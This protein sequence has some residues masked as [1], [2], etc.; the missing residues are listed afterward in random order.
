MTLDYNIKDPQGRVDQVSALIEE[1]QSEGKELT[2]TY[3]E[4]LADYIC[5]AKETKDRAVLTPNRMVTVNKRE[6]SYEGLAEQVEGEDYVQMLKSDNRNQILSPKVEITK[7]D[8]AEIPALAQLRLSIEHWEKLL[9][10]A[11]GKRAFYI[12]KALIEMRKDQYLIKQAYKPMIKF[13]SI[14]RSS[15]I[16]IELPGDETIGEDGEP[17][18]RGISLL[19]PKVVSSILC[20]YTTLNDNQFLDSDVYYLMLD[21]NILLDAALAN[22]PI[23]R[24]IIEYKINHATNEEIQQELAAEF[25]FTHTQEY[26]S[27]LWR[28]KIPKLIADV[29]SQQYL[30]WHYTFKEKGQYK[31]CNRCGQNKLAHSR[32]FS[33]NKSSRDGFYSLCKECRNAATK[34]RKFSQG[35]GQIEK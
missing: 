25:G 29:A 34:A 26:I 12:K 6:T 28:N 33:L 5:Y 10:A 16:P 21:F 9:K 18:G 3:L 1:F 19:N 23:Y 13:A 15:P 30:D 4:Y 20:N 14:S 32:Y 11:E 24:R 7:Q 2:P 35:G 27:S 8:I 17:L 22:E 31:C